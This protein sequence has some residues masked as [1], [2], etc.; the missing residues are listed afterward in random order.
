MQLSRHWRLNSQRYRLQGTIYKKDG[1]VVGYSLQNRE[2][3]SFTLAEPT[4]EPEPREEKELEPT[5][6]RDSEAVREFTEIISSQVA[7]GAERRG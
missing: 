5:E 6:E 3:P 1:E 4:K 7:P 2:A